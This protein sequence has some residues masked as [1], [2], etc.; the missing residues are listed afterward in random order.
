MLLSQVEITICP[1]PFVTSHRSVDAILE[2]DDDDRKETAY[3]MRT[4]YLPREYLSL[5]D[6]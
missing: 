4:V 1:C 5:D 6:G 3:A 2:L